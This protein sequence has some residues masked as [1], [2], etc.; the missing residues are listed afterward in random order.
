MTDP[1]RDPLDLVA[2]EFAA[3]LRRGETPAVAEYVARH[4]DL[5]DDLRELLPAV[6][7]MEQLKRHRAADPLPESVGGYRIL[8]EI[9]R[10]GMGVVYEAEGPDGRRAAV[11]V[12]PARHRA[13]PAQRERFRRGAEAAAR[14]RHPNVVPVLAAGEDGDTPYLAMEYVAGRGLDE[15][16]AGWRRPGRASGG[17]PPPARRSCRTTGRRSPG[18]GRPS[19]GRSST[20]TT[21]GCC[22]GT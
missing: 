18:S 11:K 5:A 21:T 20:P 19:P 15:V 4:P 2:E 12:L 9:G 10:G 14:L 13:D 3:R 22:T 17:R 8:R 16:I 6:A 7:H 1:D